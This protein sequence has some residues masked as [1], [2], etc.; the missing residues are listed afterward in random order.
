MNRWTNGPCYAR[1]RC[2]SR[3]ERCLNP[4]LRILSPPTGTDRRLVA[5]QRP[6]QDRGGHPDGKKKSPVSW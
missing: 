5:S 1:T 6:T 3:G 2:A 4:H